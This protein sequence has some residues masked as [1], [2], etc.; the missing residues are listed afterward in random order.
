MRRT[1]IFRRIGFVVLL[2]VAAALMCSVVSA[3]SPGKLF[4]DHFRFGFRGGISWAELVT[5]EFGA[6]AADSRRAFTAGAFWAFPVSSRFAFQPE[7]MLKHY[8]HS[9]YVVL[10]SP[11]YPDGYAEGVLSRKLDYISISSMVRF[12]PVSQGIVLPF[13]LAGPRVDFNIRAR[14]GLDDDYYDIP[15]TK[16]VTFGIDV[17]GGV[18]FNTKLPVFIDIRGSLGLTSA[19]DLLGVGF[20]EPVGDTPVA[21]TIDEL[22]VKGHMLSITAGVIFM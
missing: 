6:W 2:M 15:N 20:E 11:Y 1:L 14:Q 12:Q 16:K 8:G 3:Q 22:S 7:I 13:L 17:G 4:G 21:P 10:T 9:Y 5:G 18:V 19:F